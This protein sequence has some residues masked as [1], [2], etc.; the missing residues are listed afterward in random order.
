MSKYTT[1]IGVSERFE[2]LKHLINKKV[3]IT[4]TF[5]ISGK[6]NSPKNDMSLFTNI[7][8]DNISIHHAWIQNRL[9]K[10]KLETNKQFKFLAKISV[11]KRINENGDLINDIAFR[12]IKLLK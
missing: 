3:M 10:N 8:L 2:Q 6:S 9:F 5:K 4:G 12:P 7:K 1:V 11:R